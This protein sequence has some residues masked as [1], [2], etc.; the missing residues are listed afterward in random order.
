MR[1]IS[2]AIQFTGAPK[3]LNRPC[4]ITKSPSATIVPGSYFNVGG[5][6][7][8]RLNRPSRPGAMSAVLDVVRGPVALGRGVVTLVE[9]CVERLYNTS[10]IFRFDLLTHH[11]H[12]LQFAGKMPGS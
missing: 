8:M 4:T 9:Q 6:L 2:A 3:S 7:L 1:T 12:F 5:R 10:F 11:F